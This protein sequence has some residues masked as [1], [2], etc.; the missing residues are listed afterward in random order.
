MKKFSLLL[1][2]LAIVSLPSL[3]LAK[4]GAD[5][6]AGHMR[7]EGRGHAS[8]INSST[9]APFLLVA[10]RGRGAD[11]PAGHVR[12]GRGAEHGVGHA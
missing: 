6:P 3:A 12:R 2:T 9:A 7:G 10:R 1:S 8:L 4:Q 11:D 5:D